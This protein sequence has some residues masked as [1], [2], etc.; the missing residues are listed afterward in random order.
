M[1]AFDDWVTDRRVTR[2]DVEAFVADPALVGTL[3]R[4]ELF[5]C[6]SS[7]TTGRPGLFLHDQ[8]AIAVYRALVIVRIDLAWLNAGQWLRLTGRGFRWAAVSW[9]MKSEGKRLR[10]RRTALLRFFVSTW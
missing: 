5:A 6:M 1:A 4:G 9:N 7:G 10:F 8:H 3:Y 2:V